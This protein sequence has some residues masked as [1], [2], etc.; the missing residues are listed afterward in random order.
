MA[1][2]S[3][4]KTITTRLLLPVI[5]FLLFESSI[6][7]WVTIHYVDQTHDSSLLDSVRSLKQE[8]K[9]ENEKIYIELSEN[10][11]EIFT[12]NDQDK[13]YFKIA[14]QKQGVL[15]GDSYLPKPQQKI[16][17]EE[18]V[19]FN[20]YYHNESVRIAAIQ[21]K[22]QNLPEPVYIYVAETLNKRNKMATDILL[23][24]LIPQLFFTLLIS[25]YLFKGVIRGLSPL[26]HLTDQ[27]AQRSPHDL[28]PLSETHVVTEVRAL[29]DTI[30]QLLARLSSAITTQQRFISNAAHQ[31]RTPLAGLKLQ[32]EVALREDNISSMRPALYQMQSSADRAS[33]LITQLLTL[34]RSSPIEGSHQLNHLDLRQLVRNVCIEWVPAALEKKIELCFDDP[35]QGVWVRGDAL[36]LSELL[37]NLID[38]AISY[39]AQSGHIFIKLVSGLHPYLLVADDGLGIPLS[40][41]EHIF[42]RFYRIQGSQGVG[43]GLGLAIVKEIA[44]L[45]HAQVQLVPRKNNQTGT[46]IKVSFTL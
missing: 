18:P 36:L 39:G 4:Q 33:H 41:Q 2:S 8:I 37:A 10:A 15:A 17:W 11:L 24:D 32:T 6:S 27:L 30:N 25:L 34:A 21:V 3:L 46:C 7:Y 38:N 40:E 44:D 42:E 13:T 5:L 20:S 1:D 19:F 23:A 29:T 22:N 31:L 14:T 28:S 35:K 45:H 12:W 26:H 43:C 9:V 16:N